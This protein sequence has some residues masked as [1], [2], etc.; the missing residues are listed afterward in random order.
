M[1]DIAQHVR[2]FEKDPSDD[3]V[4]KRKT[5]IDELGQSFGK[6]ATV[7][8]ILLLANDLVASV[9][10][11]GALP[12][13]RVAEVESLIKNQSGAFVREGQELQILTCALVAALQSLEKAT[14]STGQWSRF[15]VLAAG[16]WSG[17]SFQTPRTEPRL[18]Q[19]R[20]ELI[21][22]ARGLVLGSPSTARNRAPV[23]NV[24]VIV[25]E[26]EGW[27]KF[28]EQS[29]A[30]TTRTIESL[31]TN[32]ALDREELDL[33][34]WVLSDWSTLLGQRLST[35]LPVLSAIF[36]AVEVAQLMR[37]LPGEAHKHLVLRHFAS[38]E[39]L[40]LTELLGELGEHKRTLA[41]HFHGNQIL[42]ACPRVFPLLSA[43]SGHSGSGP[44]AKVARSLD[45]W[46]ERALL[47]TAILHIA[48]LPGALV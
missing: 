10:A 15:D 41:T 8:D 35:A 6:L 39:N 21:E 26:P 11:K 29:Q 25:A 37:R 5:V 46:G 23:P 34:W 32:S 4:E 17:L 18:E 40:S 28:A 30:V 36:A 45:E 44:A 33:L 48:T 3:F 2:I 9:G 42:P 12:E 20:V 7:A 19:L 16:L 13:A 1:T 22:R 27:V 14:P 31:R 43:I 47:E 24:P 38:Q